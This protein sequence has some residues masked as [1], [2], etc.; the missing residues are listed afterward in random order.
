MNSKC[1]GDKMTTNL[2]IT[3]FACGEQQPSMT[4]PR[5]PS[6]SVASSSVAI[7]GKPPGM[8]EGVAI[9]EPGK[10]C[11]ALGGVQA[12]GERSRELAWTARRG[13]EYRGGGLTTSTAL[14]TKGALN[15]EGNALSDQMVAEAAQRWQR[16]EGQG[17]VSGV[18]GNNTLGMAPASEVP[19]A[20]CSGVSTVESAGSSSEKAWNSATDGSSRD[21]P[22][23]AD[24]SDCIAWASVQATL[25]SASA[26]LTL[27]VLAT[28][29]TSAT[30][31][32]RHR[33]I[34]A[35]QRGLTH[36][37]RVVANLHRHN[38]DGQAAG[39]DASM[40]HA[41]AAHGTTKTGG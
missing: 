31:W 27:R 34:A 18:G 8:H 23:Q 35:P 32:R 39:H 15:N 1:S 11:V 5:N 25:E 26:D 33:N 4:R 17:D 14:R 19:P 24:A 13:C 7:R 9:P 3:W 38:N 22:T 6:A 41:S 16:G 37:C 36:A 28:A 2:W 10:G 21:P 40:H 29:C 30:C 20:H 12:G